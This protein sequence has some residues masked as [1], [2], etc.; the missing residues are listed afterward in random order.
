METAV[1]LE[2]TEKRLIELKAEI[3]MSK[4]HLSSISTQKDLLCAKANLESVEI[5]GG[6]LE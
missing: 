5:V 6:K 1:A 3:E 2:E 4:R